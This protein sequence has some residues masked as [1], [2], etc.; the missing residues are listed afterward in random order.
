MCGYVRASLVPGAAPL[1]L[2]KGFF[3]E[4][5]GVLFAEEKAMWLRALDLTVDL[6]ESINGGHFM[7]ALARFPPSGFH[8]PEEAAARVQHPEFTVLMAAARYMSAAP[9]GRKPV[10]RQPTHTD[11]HLNLISVYMAELI[12]KEQ[13]VEH[14]VESGVME[15]PVG[16]NCDQDSPSPTECTNMPSRISSPTSRPAQSSISPSLSMSAPNP[17]EF[18]Q[19]SRRGPIVEGVR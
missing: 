2:S 19:L 6:P 16:Q 5:R 7:V 13:S 17:S 11:S 15:E 12:D 18:C 10:A 8:F 14:I 3:T 1:L 9:V 4:L